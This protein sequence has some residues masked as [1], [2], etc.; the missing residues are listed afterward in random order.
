MPIAHISTKYHPFV[1]DR[2][3]QS[4]RFIMEESNIP[5]DIHLKKLLDWLVS[6]R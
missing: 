1:A 2:Q 4:D 5:I 6:R 3:L